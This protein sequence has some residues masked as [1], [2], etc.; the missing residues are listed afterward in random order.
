ME[1]RTGPW[2]L[3]HVSDIVRQPAEVDWI[4]KRLAAPPV[5]VRYELEH[6]GFRFYRTWRDE[7]AAQLAQS[8]ARLIAMAPSLDA[9]ASSAVQNIH[10]LTADLGYDISHSEPRWQTS[11]FVSRPDRIDHVGELRFAENV[12][13]EAMHLH[14][15]NNEESAPL[16]QAFD[17]LVVSP[18]R[19]EPRP[20]QGV[21]H[22]L[23]VFTCLAV[24]FRTLSGSAVIDASGHN[25]IAQRLTTIGSEVAALNMNALSA[26]LTPR[27]AA[28]AS[29]WCRLASKAS[30]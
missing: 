5:D 28:L 10:L 4:W 13:H 19:A 1:D 8:A 30:S 3:D 25:H 6:R 16:V 29:E 14:L 23:F 18:W 17:G 9:A 22:G 11:I 20:M 15:T 21:L 27:G 24:Y 26:G 12:I 2:D 7:T